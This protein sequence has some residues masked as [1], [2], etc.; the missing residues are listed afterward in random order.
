MA[1]D[2]TL[3]AELKNKIKG[4]VLSDQYSLG[5][6]ATDA[7]IYQIQPQ[8]VVIPKDEEDVR[9]AIGIARKNKLKIL[10]RGAGTSLAGQTVAD[11]LVLDFSKD[12]K[13]VV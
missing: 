7:S 10:P 3:I 1:M 6:Y 4:D 11:G 13:S 5:M 12:R 9:N 8:V 2:H